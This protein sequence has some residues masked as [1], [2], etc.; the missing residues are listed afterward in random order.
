MNM[1]KWLKKIKDDIKREKPVI[2]LTRQNNYILAEPVNKGW[3]INKSP[4]LSKNQLIR[5]LFLKSD[6]LNILL[7]I[8]KT[9]NTVND[10]ELSE[11]IRYSY[12]IYLNTL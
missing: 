5:I 6:V 2:L 1:S 3:R 11:A 4:I 7:H 12:Q 9:A 8:L 10:K